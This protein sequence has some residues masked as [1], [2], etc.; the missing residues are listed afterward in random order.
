MAQTTMATIP[1]QRAT[2]DWLPSPEK[3]TMLEMVAA[4]LALDR[5][6][7]KT[8]A[9]LHT[10]ESITADLG[11][12]ERV[13]THVAIAFAASV[14]PFTKITPVVITAVIAKGSEWRQFVIKV[15]NVIVIEV[16]LNVLLLLQGFYR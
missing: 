9:K 8:P 3:L 1:A 14:H 4:T 15:E 12:I 13:D 10:A 7:T 16:F 5:V 2:R 6:I 11:E